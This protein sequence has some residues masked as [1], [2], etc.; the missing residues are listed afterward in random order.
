MT[1][2]VIE[3]S[4]DQLQTLHDDHAT[5]QETLVN[6][7]TCGKVLSDDEAQKYCPYCGTPVNEQLPIKAGTKPWN[8]GIKFTDQQI[9]LHRDGQTVLELPRD[10]VM[11]A[12]KAGAAMAASFAASR[13]QQRSGDSRPESKRVSGEAKNKDD[14]A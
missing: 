14:E 1:H 9:I 12:L 10:Q 3:K 13:R 4:R 5:V 7:R 11:N 2:N 8:L 6:C